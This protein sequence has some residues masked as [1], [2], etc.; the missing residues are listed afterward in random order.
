MWGNPNSAMSFDGVDDI[1]IN[2][3]VSDV[4]L[5]SNYTILATCLFLPANIRNIVLSNRE[6]DEGIVIRRNEST[7]LLEY[8]IRTSDNYFISSSVDVIEDNIVSCIGCVLDNS[9]S[10]IF[11]NGLQNIS[12][13]LTVTGDFNTYGE[14]YIGNYA[15]SW[16]LY[17]TVYEIKIYDQ[18]LT[19]T[20]VKHISAQM[21]R[22]IGRQ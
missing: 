14:T 20:Q 12:S 15:G 16:H 1:L 21:M 9:V 3:E 22:K 6:D 10:N 17:G 7:K 4:V 2:S 11:I 19:P 8:Y 18:A 5:S 13:R